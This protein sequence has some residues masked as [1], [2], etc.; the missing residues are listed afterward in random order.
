MAALNLIEYAEI[1]SQFLDQMAIQQSTSGWMEANSNPAQYVG[2]KT[3]RVPTM[4]TSGL[5][6]YGRGTGPDN[7]G[8]Y[9]GGKVRIQYENYTLEVDRA[10][11]FLWDRHDID[12][13]GFIL[14]APNVMRE[15]AVRHAIPELDSFRYSKIASLTTANGTPKTQTLTKD[16]ILEEFLTQ[17]RTAQDIHGQPTN[18]MVAIM[19]F[20]TWNMLEQAT[21]VAH[22]AVDPVSF[23]QG[24]LTFEVN[25][26]N[27]IPIIPVSSDR[28]KTGYIFHPNPSG[29][30]KGFEPAPGAKDINWIIMPRD[31]P[32]AISKHDNLKIFSPDINQDGDDWKLQYRRYG[33]LWIMNSR[34]QEIIL[35]LAP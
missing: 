20:L 32:I 4:W 7:R 9:P 34:F 24:G 16:N 23:T 35:S 1:W 12:E 28:L 26:I 30:T 29:Q 2:G 10:T 5:G 18:G 6:D 25:T 22:M 8:Q 14:T 31:V 13:S 15:F 3:F 33:D 19:S 17:I 11:E 21:G 27:G